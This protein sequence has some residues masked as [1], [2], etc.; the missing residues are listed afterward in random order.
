MPVPVDL[1]KLGNV[2]RNDVVKKAAYDKLVT[3]VNNIDTSRFVLKTNYDTDESK[4][5]KKI[6]DTSDLVKKT[7]YSSKVSEIENKISSISGLLTTPALTAVENKISDVSNLVKK[8]DYDTKIS[9]RNLLI[10]V[11]IN[12]LLLQNLLS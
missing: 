10:I 2:I 4:L 8:I 3:K 11:M 6:T 9:K 12:I 5:E 1:N 7:G